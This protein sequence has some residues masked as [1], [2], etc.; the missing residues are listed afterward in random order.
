MKYRNDMSPEPRS[1]IKTLKKIGYDLN[2]AIADIIDNSITA[3]A[4]NIYVS[5]PPEE[6]DPFLS[7]FD[8]GSSKN[9]EY[10]PLFVNKIN[11]S[12]I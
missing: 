4:K 6:E 3:Q 8:D 2:S 7:I 9:L 5:C 12:L 11:P 10:S 1:H